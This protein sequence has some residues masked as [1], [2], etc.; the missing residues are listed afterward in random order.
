VKNGLRA[1]VETAP[2]C[3]KVVGP[4]GTVLHM[5]SAG[6]TMVGADCADQ[7]IGKNIYDLIV[8]EDREKVS[9]V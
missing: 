2:E 8:P 6:L 1:I 9:R 4:D 5:N 7:V 3:V